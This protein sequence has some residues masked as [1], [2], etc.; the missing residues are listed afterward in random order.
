[1]LFSL[2]QRELEGSEFLRSAQVR[3]CLTL[4]VRSERLT[5]GV[6][7]D[8]LNTVGNPAARRSQSRTV[9]SSVGHSDVMDAPRALAVLSAIVSY[10]YL[11][12]PHPTLGSRH[13][14]CFCMLS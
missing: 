14:A 11:L 9:L 1:M 5:S 8:A 12:L 13:C 6:A 2:R 4:D 3:S 10:A 7:P